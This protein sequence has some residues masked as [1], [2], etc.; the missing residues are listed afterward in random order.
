MWESEMKGNG[1]KRDMRVWTEGN[2]TKSEMLES[3]LKGNGTKRDM[4]ESEMKGD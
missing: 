4:R 3:E 1:T 2:G